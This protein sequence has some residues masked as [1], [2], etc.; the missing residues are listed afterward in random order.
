MTFPKA[1]GTRKREISKQ[2]L[3]SFTPNLGSDI[4]SLLLTSID[5]TQTTLVECGRGLFKNVNT[6]RWKSAGVILGG[7]LPN[8]Y[9][10]YPLCGTEPDVFQW[11]R[12]GVLGK[13]NILET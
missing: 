8:T 2:N 1:S 13:Q 9:C 3:Q 11:P 6:K 10:H 7:R 4:L 5:R 12:Q